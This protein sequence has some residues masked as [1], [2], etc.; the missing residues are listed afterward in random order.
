MGKKIM[1]LGIALIMLL[2]LVGLT[3]CNGDLAQ[4]KTAA[5]A[6]ITNHVATLN[7]NEYTAENWTLIVQRAN[8]GKAEVVMK[9]Q[10]RKTYLEK[11]L[12]EKNQAATIDDV[13]FFRNKFLGIYDGSLVGFSME[14]NITETSLK[15]RSL[16]KSQI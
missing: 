11:I 7:A 14:G 8:E 12:K 15:S 13:S 1:V 3:A 16:L 2:S 5:K 6:E 9:I 4:Y 10:A